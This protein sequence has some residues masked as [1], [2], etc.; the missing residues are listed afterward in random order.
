MQGGVNN[1]EYGVNSETVYMCVSDTFNVVMDD[2]L[3]M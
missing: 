2:I 3:Y 1:D